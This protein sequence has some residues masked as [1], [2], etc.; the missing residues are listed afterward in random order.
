MIAKSNAN[1]FEQ[2]ADPRLSTP[3][4][5]SAI[6]L[7]FFVAASGIG[8]GVMSFIYGHHAIYNTTREMPWGILISTYAFWA[9]TSTGLCIYAAISHLFGGNRMAVVSNRMV[10]MSIITILAAFSTIGVE[11]ANPHR[12]L[13]YNVLSPNPTS[14]IWWMGTLYGMAVGCMVLEFFSIVTGIARMAL[15]MGILAAITEVGAN[16]CLGG[17]FATLPS[18]PYWYGA[19]LPIYFLMSAFLSGAAAAILFNYLAYKIRNEKMDEHVAKA[20]ASAG[21]AMTLALFLYAVA[22]FWRL[23]SFFVGGT[24][25]GR[26]AAGALI[27]GPLAINFWGVEVV[28]GLVLPLLL[29]VGS[30]MK[31]VSVMAVAGF[32]VL[33]GQFVSRFDMVVVGQIVP[34][35]YGW[36]GAPKYLSYLPSLYEFG[37]I[38]GGIGVVFLGFLIGERMFGKLF[39]Q[40]PHH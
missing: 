9:I 18:R 29:I 6:V 5:N 30:R 31:N 23:I 1:I 16:S 33:V 35:D 36:N 11:I 27:D 28:V 22:T 19:Q 25:L 21:K 39:R 4:M 8:C 10:F 24:E 17:V 40:D 14:N 3:G 34:Q 2:T 38:A 32:L 26:I 7:L 13:L 15:F 20:M 37:V 12:M